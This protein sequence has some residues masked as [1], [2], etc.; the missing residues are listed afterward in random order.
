MKRKEKRERRER[1]REEPQTD[2]KKI[3][4]KTKKI[5]FEKFICF[6]NVRKKK[7]ILKRERRERERKRK[8]KRKRTIKLHFRGITRFG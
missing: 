4:K 1:K 5:F 6:K 3:N 2:H 7:N 8:R